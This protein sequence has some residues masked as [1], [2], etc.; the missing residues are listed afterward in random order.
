[1]A[2]VF[3]AWR[4]SPQHLAARH[5][6]AAAFLGRSSGRRVSRSTGL[7]YARLPFRSGICARWRQK[8]RT[9]RSAFGSASRSLLRHF[10]SPHPRPP[11]ATHR[12][13]SQRNWT[14]KF[15]PMADM[16]PV[17]PLPCS[18]FL[19]TSCRFATLT[20]TKPK[21]RPT[22]LWV[23]S[24]GCCRRSAFS[25]TRTAVLPVSMGWAQQSRIALLPFFA[26][27]TPLDNRYCM[28]RIR[29]TN[30]CRWAEQA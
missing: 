7:T 17:I 19:P 13:I 20:P 26:T 12:A 5:R 15:F 8:C 23:R 24:T 30:G 28:R 2:A 3:P 9:G 18:K 16:F 6:L 1:M 21:L 10:P 11:S 27:T 22:H 25:V 29:D 14:G 4:G